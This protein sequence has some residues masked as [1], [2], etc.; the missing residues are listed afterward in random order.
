MA[1]RIILI[2][3]PGLSIMDMWLPVLSD[4][5][6]RLPEAEFCCVVP[7][8]RQIGVMDIDSD[9]IKIANPIFDRVV[10]PA[11][12]GRWKQ[13]ASFA[14][15]RA[16]HDSEAVVRAWRV[17][18]FLSGLAP[19]E[20]LKKWALSYMNKRA[21]RQQ[22]EQQHHPLQILRERESVVLLDI[23][24]VDKPYMAEVKKMMGDKTPKFSLFHGI[25]LPRTSGQVR[26]AGKRSN[27]GN[28]T[29]LLFSGHEQNEYL[30]Q[31]G[32]NEDS[33]RIVGIPRHEEKWIEFIDSQQS[34]QILELPERF[35]FLI[36]RGSNEG[37]WITRDKKIEA[38]QSIKAVAVRQDLYVLVK[39][40][41]KED[42][43]DGVAE[44]VFGA[45]SYGQTWSF[46]SS[47]PLVLGRR[48]QF[49]ISLDSGVAIDM[50][51]IETPIIEY[52]DLSNSPIDSEIVGG[53]L[54]NNGEVV[55]GIRYFGLALGA[56]DKSQLMRQ[57]NRVLL[58]RD[59][60]VKSLRENY[61]AFFPT[62]E[63]INEKISSLIISSL[64]NNPRTSR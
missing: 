61:E 59:E 62:V 9:V 38:L 48:C 47:H 31:F 30:R 18:R 1:K 51:R 2:C 41:P 50:A 43:D 27:P 63:G 34:E 19:L 52:S 53:Y 3:S 14:E 16:M 8:A 11:T 60:V 28:L 56:S 24:Q 64:I 55:T 10:F 44:E 29:A 5:R 42:R 57:V 40:H 25:K 39:K 33:T 32:L 36:S 4:L 46:T 54:G 13:A 37:G 15:A 17:G 23:H 6:A 21:G 12:S 58:H 45:D 35:I 7:R 22:A 26:L 49:A 20:P